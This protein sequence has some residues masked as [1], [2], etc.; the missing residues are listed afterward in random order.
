VRVEDLKYNTSK[1]LIETRLL[2][3]NYSYLFY[4][5]LGGVGIIISFF[6]TSK[7]SFNLG[8]VFKCDYE[9]EA[10]SKFVMKSISV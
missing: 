3:S 5:H 9:L 10:E 7:V 2:Y 1:V 8:G 6:N 4:L